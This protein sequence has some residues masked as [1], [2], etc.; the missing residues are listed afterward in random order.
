MR[1]M[2]ENKFDEHIKKKLLDYEQD[3]DPASWDLL[4]E[5]LDQ[6]LQVEDEDASDDQDSF[7]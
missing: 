2:S 3:Y 1:S 5:R 4:N 7:P 6:D